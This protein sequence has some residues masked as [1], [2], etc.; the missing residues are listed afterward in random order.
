[1]VAFADHHFFDSS[2]PIDNFHRIIGPGTIYIFPLLT[3]FNCGQGQQK[4]ADI[5]LENILPDYF[6]SGFHFDH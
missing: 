2:I 6:H 1:M 5:R 4:K 3:E